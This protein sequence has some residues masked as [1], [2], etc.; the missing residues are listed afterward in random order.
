MT[1]EEVRTICLVW[2]MERLRH[3]TD[4]T[5]ILSQYTVVRQNCTQ[6]SCASIVDILRCLY[7]FVLTYSLDHLMAL[8]RCVEFDGNILTSGCVAPN[9]PFHP[10]KHV[11]HVAGP[12][13]IDYISRVHENLLGATV[14]RGRKGGVLMWWA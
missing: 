1:D 8:R 5:Y 12:S 9:V 6:F 10:M 11:I 7:P 14:R 2:S 13:H 4:E 3:A